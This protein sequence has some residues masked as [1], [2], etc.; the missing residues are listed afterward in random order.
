MKDHSREISINEHQ[1]HS[2]RFADDIALLADIEEE[3][4]LMLYILNSSL[5]KLKLKLTNKK[6]VMVNDKLIQMQTINRCNK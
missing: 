4:S 5:D 3:L 2:I 1:I 6:K